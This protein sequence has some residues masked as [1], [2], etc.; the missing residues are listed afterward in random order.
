MSRAFPRALL[1]L[2]Q[3]FGNPPARLYLGI[4]RRAAGVIF[5]PRWKRSLMIIAWY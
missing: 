3:G 2:L 4:D 5:H 1:P